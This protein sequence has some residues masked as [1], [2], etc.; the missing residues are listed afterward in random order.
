M[1]G[2]YLCESYYRVM[3]NDR[4]SGPQ[5]DYGEWRSLALCPMTAP[6]HFA[7]TSKKTLPIGSRPHMAKSGHEASMDTCLRNPF[8]RRPLR[9][10]FRDQRQIESLTQEAR[11]LKRPR[12]KAVRSQPARSG[13]PQINCK[14]ASLLPMTSPVL[15]WIFQPKFRSRGPSESGELP[16]H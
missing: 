14:I 5:P 9:W 15:C 7:A 11:D 16:R 2:R 8:R 1:N 6:D 13:K 4:I 3:F 10:L 12:Q